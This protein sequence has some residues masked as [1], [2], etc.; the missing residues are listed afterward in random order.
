[1][2]RKLAVLSMVCMAV[3][4]MT[5]TSEARA[6]GRSFKVESVFDGTKAGIAFANQIRVLAGLP[7]NVLVHTPDGDVNGLYTETLAPGVAGLF[8]ST[9]RK[10]VV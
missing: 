8:L 3:C 10:G 6:R 4:A 2:L 1:M 9:D 7:G 5:S